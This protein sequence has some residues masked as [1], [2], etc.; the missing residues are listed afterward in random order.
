MVYSR[1]VVEPF[2][3]SVSSFYLEDAVVIEEQSYFEH[4]DFFHEQRVD[5]IRY[6][7]VNHLL[8]L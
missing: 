3:H 7:K 4:F 6:L 8:R 2:N 1:V 5:F